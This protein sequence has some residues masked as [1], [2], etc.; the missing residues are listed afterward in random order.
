[1]W[2]LPRLSVIKDEK[3]KGDLEEAE[4]VLEMGQ[5]SRGALIFHL[6]HSRFQRPTAA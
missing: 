3:I 5:D 4:F 6:P 2:V 1:M